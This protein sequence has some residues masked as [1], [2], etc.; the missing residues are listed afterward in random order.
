M[1]PSSH[2]TPTYNSVKDLLEDIGESIQQEASKKAQERSKGLLKGKLSQ[3]TYTNDGS[4]KEK[5]LDPCN[6]DHTKHTNVK[7]NPQQENPCHGRVQE[8]FSDARS[9]QCT[10]NRI[11]DSEHN[12]NSIGACAPYRR[13]HICDYNLENIDPEKITSTHNLLA[14]VLLVAKHEGQTLVEKHEEHKRTNPDSKIC[15][16]LARS[17]ADIADIVRGRDLFLGNQQE[18]KKLEENLKKI[19]RKIHGGLTDAKER[20][21]DDPNFYHLREDWWNENRDQV[22]KAITCN[23]GAADDYFKKS[24]SRVYSFSNGQCG[25]KQAKVPTDLDYVPQFLRWFDEWADDF[26]RIRN[27]K[28]KNI[29]KECRGDHDGDKYCSHNGYDCTKIIGN[30]EFFSW[31]SKCTGCSVKCRLYEL[32]IGNQRKEFEKQNKKYVKE[33]ETYESNTGISNSNIN[34]EYNKEFYE[35]LKK[36]FESVDDFLKLL[37]EGTYCKEKL[38]EEEKIDFTITGN[39]GIFSR[40]QYCQVCPD[41]GVA[42]K[43][44]NC[45]VIENGIKCRKFKTYVL[46]KDVTPTTINIIDSGDEEGNITQKLQDF[47]KNENKENGKN[48]QTWECYYENSYNNKCKMKSAKHEDQ[49][50]RYVMTFHK[51]FDLWVKNL[52]RD[53]IKWENDL[54]ECINNTNVTDCSNKCN[55]NCI[56]FNRWVKQKEDEWEKVKN[57][58]ENKKGTWK[59]YYNKL[60]GLFEGYFFPVMN[61]LNKDEKK[62]N[63]LKKK[64]EEI[65]EFSK[66]KER[67]EESEGAIKVLLAHL[68]EIGERCIDNNSNESCDSSMDT[69]TNPC[70]ETRGSKPTKTVK[71]LA[72]MMQHEAHTQLE[73]RGGESNLKGDASK[74]EYRNEGDAEGFKDICSINEKHSNSTYN[75]SKEPCGGKG[76]VYD[77]GTPWKDGNSKSSTPDVYIRPRREHMC[78]SN[79]EYLETNDI[80]FS[81]NNG[82]L[83]N[84]SFLGDVLLAA[85]YEVQ[86]IKDLYQQNK[87]KNEQTSQNGLTDETT[88]CRA[89]RYSFADI[90]D[91]I[92][93]RDL[94]VDDDGSKKMETN[95]KVI[96]GKI[97]DQLSEIQ[98]KYK[99]V[100]ND[101]KQLRSDWWEANRHHVWRAMKCVIEKGNI[102]KC[103][104]IPIEDYIP[105]RLRWMT[106]WAEWYCKMQKREY[107]ELE[108]ACGS[109][110]SKDKGK[111]CTK[112]DGDVCTKCASQ[113]K[114]YGNNIKTWQ[115][116][117]EI[118]KNKYQQLY[119]QAQAIATNPGD[120]VF[121]GAGPDYQQVVDF[122]AQ[123]HKANGVAASGAT[124]PKRDTNGGDSVY[125]S[126]AGY[127]HQEI[128][129]AGC[130][131]QTQFCEKENGVISSTGARATPNEKYAFR[132]KP[133]FYDDACGCG[134]NIKPPAAPKKK[135][136]CNGIKTLLD[137]SRGGKKGIRGCNLKSANYKWKCGDLSLVTDEN[138]CMPPR[139]EKLCIYYFG[140]NAEIPKIRTQDNLSDGFIKSAAGETFLSWQKYK[141]DNNG[142]GKLQSK[143]EGGEIPEDFKR[144]M[145]YTFGDYRDFLFGTDIS[146]NHGEGS[147]LKKKID[148]LFPKNGSKNPGELSRKDWWK[149]HGPKIWEAMLCALSYDT[150]QNN[151]NVQTRQ[152]LRERNDYS[153]IKFSDNKSTLQNFAE[154][155]QFLRWFTEWSDEFCKKQSQE[156]KNLKVKCT[157]CKDNPSADD[158]KNRCKQCKDQCAIYKQ[159][160]TD[161]KGQWT[162]QS[163]K[164]EKLYQR[165][166]NKIN[167]F[168]EEE[169]HVVEYLKPLIKASD[170]SDN[171]ST[172]GKYINEKGYINDCEESKQKNFDKNNSADNEKEYALRD[173]PHNHENKCNCKEAVTHPASKK[174]EV[175]QKEKKE[176]VYTD[177]KK[178]LE[179]NKGNTKSHGCTGKQYKGWKCNFGSTN[180]E[181]Q[182]ICVPPR[183]EKLCISD[184]GTCKDKTKDALKKSFI[185]CAT[186]ETHFAWLYYKENNKDSQDELESG[187]I[188]EDFLRIMYYTFS[189]YNDIFFGTDILKN[190]GKTKQVINNINSFFE[191]TKGNEQEV[192]KERENWWEQNKSDIWKGMLCALTNGITEEE[193]KNEFKTKYSYEELNKKTNGTP[194]LQEFSSRSQFLRWF[195][196][197]SDEFCRERKKLE[198]KVEQDCKEAKEYEGCNKQKNKVKGGCVSACEEYKKYITGKQTQYDKQKKTFDAVKSGGE[199]EYNDISTKDP[200][201]YLKEN[202]LFGSCSCMEKAKT[203]TDYWENPHT[204]YE[205]PDHSKKCQCPTPPCEIV[206]GIL[207]TKDG[208]GYRDGCRHKYKTPLGLVGWECGKKSGGEGGK[209]DTTMCIPPRRR[210]LYV[211]NLHEFTGNSQDDLR[212][213]FI[214]CAAIETFFSWHEYK[215]E[216]Q[217]EKEEQSQLEGRVVGGATSDEEQDKLNGGNIPEEFKRQMF[218]TLADYRDILY[219]GDTVNGGANTDTLKEKINKVF[220]NGTPSPQ[221]PSE[222]SCKDWWERY[223]KDIWEGMLCALTYD[224]KTK[225]KNDEVKKALFVENDGTLKNENYKYETVSFEGG[226]DNTDTSSAKKH[227]DSPTLTTKL[228]DFIKRP[229]YFRWLEEWADEFC[230]KKK[231]IID[232][233]KVDCRGKNENIYCGDDGFDC[234]KIRPNKDEI[235]SDFNCQSCA[236][237]CRS[238]KQWISAKRT[239]FNKQ[240]QKYKTEIQNVDNNKN[241]NG[242]STTL[243]EKY[244]K[245]TDFLDNLKDGPC[246]KNNDGE[247]KINFKEEGETFGPSENCVPCPVFGVEYNKYKFHDVTV[248]ECHGKTFQATDNFENTK[249]PKGNVDMLVIDNNENKFPDDLKVCENSGIFDG[250]KENKWSCGNVC[251][252]DICKVK[253]VK[254]DKN[255]EEYIPMRVLFKR[256]VENFLEDYN[257]INDKISYCINN[258]KGST[259]ING[260][261]N[262]CNCVGKWIDQKKKEWEKVRDRYLKPFNEKKSEICFN[263]KTFLERLL[264]QTDVNKAIEPFENINDFEDTCGGTDYKN[265]NNPEDKKKD[266][267]ECLLNKLEEKIKSCKIKHDPKGK[268]CSNESPTPTNETDTPVISLE[269]FPPPFC[270]VPP[271]PCSDKSATNVVS[272]KEVAKEVQVQAKKTMLE[273]SGKDGGEN[274]ESV[275]KANAALGEYSRS[276]SSDGFKQ[277]CSIDKK[278]SNADRGRSDNP[279]N[280]KDP[281]RLEIGEKWKTK[282]KENPFHTEVYMPPRREHMCISNL[283]HL[284]TKSEGLKGTNAIHSLLGDVLLTAKMEGQDIKNKLTTKGDDSAICRATKYSFGD[285]GDIIKG[286]DLWELNYGQK[287]TQDTLVEI[288]KQIKEQI[289]DETIKGKYACDTDDNKYINLRKDWWEANR[290][291]VWEAMICESIKGRNIKC[292]DTPPLDDYIPQRLRW[293]TEWAEWYCKYQ[294]QEY[295]ILQKVCKDCRSKGGQCMNGSGDCKKCT[296]TCNIFKENI[297]K[298]EDQWKQMKAKYEEL[299]NKAKGG[300]ATTSGTGSSK[301]EN[302]V[303]EFLRKLQQSNNANKIY[304][305]AEGYVHQEL[306]NMGCKEQTRFCENPSGST[307][308]D[309]DKD[310][311]YAFRE[312]P[313]KYKDKCECKMPLPP[314]SS[315][316]PT[317]NKKAC[318]IADEILKK[319][320]G[321]TSPI[322]G[323][324]PKN[325]GNN[326]AEWMCDETKFKNGEKG[327]CMPPR[328]QK[329]CLNKLHNLTH[330]TPY[331][332]RTA[333]IESAAVETFFLWQ[334]YKKDKNSDTD[335]QQKLKSGTIPDDF[336]RQMFYTFGDY[337]DIFFGKDIGKD[338]YTVNQNINVV[339]A[340][341]RKLY[342][343]IIRQKWWEL[344]GPE[345]WEGMLCALQ[346]AG[347][348]YTIKNTYNY[349]EVTFTGDS[350]GA[351]LSEFASRP[352]FLR[353]LTEWGENF[354]R[355]RIIQ[356]EILKKECKGCTLRDGG[357]ICDKNGE[358]CKQCTTACEQYQ[359]WLEKWQELYDKQNQRYT[360]VKATSPYNE[361]SDVKQS[362]DAYEYLGKKLKNIICTIGTTT[363]YCNCMDETS[364]TDANKQKAITSL[365]YPPKEIEGRCTCVPDECNALSVNDSGFPDAGVF[366]GG[367]YNRK[368]K[369]FEEHVPKK[370]DPPQYDPTNDI[371]KTTIPVAIALA[372]GS[373]AFLYLKVIYIHICCVYLCMLCV[374]VIYIYLIY[375]FILKKKKKGNKKPK[376][377]VDLLRVL[378]I[379]KGEYGMPTK[380][381]PNRYIPYKCSQ[382][383]GKSY[384]YM[385]GDTDEDIYIGDISSSDI[386]SSESEYEE[387]DINDIYPYQ[388]PKYKT[389]IEVVLEPSTRDIPSSDTPSADTPT[390][391]PI[392]D[393]EWNELKHDFISGILENAQKDLP[394]D[395]ISANTPMNTQPNTLYFDNPEEN[396][397]IMSIHD[398]DLYTG[399]EYNYDINM[400]TNTNND[401]PISSKND[402]Y[403][404]TDLIN[405][406]LNSDQPIDIYD[407]VLKRKENE[408]FGTNHPKNTS[409]NSVAKLTNSDPV[410]NQ[411]DLFN[412]WLDRNRDMCEKWDTN[413]KKEELLDKLKEEWNKDN[414]G[415]DIYTINGNKT[416]NTNV[417]IEIDMDNPKPIHQFSNMDSNVD[418]LTMDT[419]EDDI[420]YDVNDDENPSVDDISMNHNKVDVP[421]KVHVEMK[422]LNNTSNGSL[423]E[424]LP[425]SDVWNI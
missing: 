105:Q 331:H 184:L 164:Y 24:S 328:R 374:Y 416:L 124:R 58:F 256:W 8:R 366:G 98:G 223:G 152:N 75:F 191:N 268:T 13:L 419:M 286:T 104:G 381:S 361:D 23:A 370:I 29:K 392:N 182:E 325:Y 156:Y 181:N 126:A 401:I 44:G 45:E 347:G 412:K 186:M 246:T 56:C 245:A 306:P 154:R 342:H 187:K 180:K 84:D 360:E 369:G 90:G 92:R 18:K 134:Q 341:F 28:L 2:P 210:R 408:L 60:N 192:K 380:R 243:K 167:N 194:S 362:K 247:C 12:D 312:Y 65:I 193:K 114:E 222:N 80:P 357:K 302:D 417:S 227:E 397:F 69:K 136:D 297:K 89:I 99:T 280:W 295:K 322:D 365:E 418:T 36:N 48:Y 219:I 296:E 199:P 350:S 391:K 217:K 270:N 211:K 353:W 138:T 221:K 351:K 367:I 424:Q 371:L 32:W 62:W 261:E 115:N 59:N 251:D 17:F 93:G 190:N 318:E 339:F 118:I 121:V 336:K 387:L 308:S 233:I 34:R 344:H 378:D 125:S 207:G 165:A 277:L 238:Y 100:G 157:E 200:P 4:G 14:D 204:T 77:I 213:A 52:L 284:D 224:T 388:S 155:P 293:M 226:F 244:T 304:A 335:A 260:C 285:I 43:D 415:G 420:Y 300:G 309:K 279:C 310:N 70:S 9:S 113:C 10:Y 163:N 72:E 86:K 174:S 150:T 201:E 202:C 203:I 178:P 67:N 346:K 198:D 290:A 116:Q 343:G 33:I 78:T 108:G 205:N 323:C 196:E 50:H 54:K 368:C 209:G 326:Y 26:C 61:E 16:A 91:I 49:K 333:F 133:K 314:P 74:G 355:D 321:E 216:K 242:F 120:T 404:G 141:T 171:Y 334:K 111:K 208:T 330:K 161:W 364:S 225:E 329:L 139:R 262:K 22:W 301:D 83:I 94:W 132:E 363:A 287:K 103:N 352:Q 21:G 168:T 122:F 316:T 27:H 276:G 135:N 354:C 359:R 375:V 109:C 298:W 112:D 218:Y 101:Y 129:Y 402:V 149:E 229:P 5:P 327:A 236:I 269:P 175:L 144:Q 272:V 340:R 146:K 294:S 37:N 385:E 7:K 51:F 82:K 106:E 25:N 11:K 282:D 254:G 148:L 140:N 324:Y 237:S 130:Q 274:R 281:K 248:K 179:D 206:D 220:Q 173:Y 63:N 185:N 76:D 95:L 348:Y 38:K 73:E 151:I 393:E 386:T 230:R 19:F 87:G 332:L 169:K 147:K 394:K 345:I 288:F 253:N 107:Y 241:D 153:K 258:G 39:K 271:N 214:E 390:N 398:R 232:K 131:E 263:V 166:L 197:W 376:S 172:A 6:L 423:E 249:D 137:Q 68:K 299:Y 313:H 337:R 142:G 160:I 240:E 158:C 15:T 307:S 250:I 407:E 421:K 55:K 389:L 177:V 265:S 53:S 252:L 88:A 259:C 30:E 289:T 283:E 97:N 57:L 405:D 3:A 143:L 234:N 356:L 47:C 188:P 399:E 64:L 383:K 411:L 409:N 291:K 195:T 422:I 231:N 273:R 315:P 183:R 410:M 110:M 42:C 278:H 212:K 162:R 403:S 311:E 317:C 413:N 71:Q 119:G 35:K 46:P 425:I 85:K 123:L 235:F 406:S 395:N 320:N 170:S 400:S 1:A 215:K 396:P 267:V 41:C 255:V 96:F 102:T 66:G 384:I 377:P 305:T 239:E 373:I 127:V 292:D 319:S 358:G 338:M 414:D 81:T 372:L 159:F 40:S 145:F 117:W 79:L 257:K 379:H 266:V 228:T 176:E 189:D 275:L 31:D 20:Y 128:G 303:V 264:P 382:Y 349:K